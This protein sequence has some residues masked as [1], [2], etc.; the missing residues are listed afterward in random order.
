MRRRSRSSRRISPASIVL[1][2]PTVVGDQQVDPGQLE[3]LA[4]GLQ[5]V[6][7]EPDAGAERRLEEAGVGGGDGV[8]AN[9]AGVGGEEL[10]IIEPLT[11]DP[12]PAG[13][14]DDMGVKLMLPQ[15]RGTLTLG[16]VVDAGRR[17]QR[18]VAFA[19]RRLD[20]LDEPPPL[21]RVNQLAGRRPR[22]RNN[23]DQPP[24]LP[25]SGNAQT[26][27]G[28]STRGRLS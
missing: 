3:R 1:P 12:G 22:C 20:R 4:Q 23:Q 16:I 27:R 11:P 17:H 13:I 19:S 6:G 15:E 26:P 8:P 24:R 25:P 18:C 28:L 14:G 9:R 10:G 7:I 2:R 5:L 21:P